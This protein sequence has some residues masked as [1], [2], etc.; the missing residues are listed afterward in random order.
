MD[1]FRRLFGGGSTSKPADEA[2]LLYVR[3]SRCGA[4]VSV[5]VHPYNDMAVEYD[6][7]ENVDGYRLR[8]E[9]MDSRCFRLMYAD[10]SFDRNRRELS[11]SIEGGEFISKD[12]YE[13]LKAQ[14]AAPHKPEASASHH[15]RGE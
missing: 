2:L 12:E 4:P 15:E 14:E 8:K 13:R 1:F 10:L 3:C 11:R 5:R 7:R 9:I 6:D